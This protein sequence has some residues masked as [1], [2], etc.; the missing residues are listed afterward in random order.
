MKIPLQPKYV[1]LIA[2]VSL[3]LTACG[4]LFPTNNM[5]GGM[6]PNFGNWGADFDSN[7]EQIYFTATNDRGEYL[8]YSGG[9]ASGGMMGSQLT[10]AS[11]HGD[12]GQGGQHLMHMQWMEAPDIRFVTL[13]KEEN[14]HQGNEHE[15][16]HGEE[17][18][19]E[20]FHQA[21]VLGRHPDGDALNRDMPR[22]QI[23]DN[24]LTDLYKFL[25]TLP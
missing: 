2:L 5:P 4:L 23:S 24:D 6:G 9:P 16:A 18:D 20:T 22:W 15:D 21:V 14:G 10:C 8:S 3:F 17:Y 13:S 12:D 1:I 25:K 19:L 11:C 7:G